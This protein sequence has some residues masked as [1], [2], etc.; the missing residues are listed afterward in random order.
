M[1]VVAWGFVSKSLKNHEIDDELFL[2]NDIPNNITHR[3]VGKKLPTH[4]VTSFC[5]AFLSKKHSH[6]KKWPLILCFVHW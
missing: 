4:K 2:V 5:K 3:Y 6:K 1:A